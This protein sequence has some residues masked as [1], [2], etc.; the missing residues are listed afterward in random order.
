[1]QWRR[2]L[3]RRNGDAAYW[4]AIGLDATSQQRL[5]RGR[6]YRPTRLSQP[7]WYHYGQSAKKALKALLI[8]LDSL[9]P[10]SHALDRLVESLEPKGVRRDTHPSRA[11]FSGSEPGL[12]P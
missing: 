4:R 1:M 10:Y 12:T 2:R 9:P 8:A 11:L 6:T 3:E 7:E 5:G